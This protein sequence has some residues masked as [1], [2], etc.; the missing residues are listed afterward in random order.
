MPIY[1]FQFIEELQDFRDNFLGLRHIIFYVLNVTLTFFQVLWLLPL[2][3]QFPRRLSDQPDGIVRNLVLAD[4]AGDPVP[5]LERPERQ[6]EEEP[7]VNLDRRRPPVSQRVL[8]LHQ[9][10]P[11]AARHLRL[12]VAGR[13]RSLDDDVV[14]TGAFQRDVRRGEL[15]GRRCGILLAA[16][17]QGG[18]EVG[19]GGAL[20]LQKAGHRVLQ[21]CQESEDE[22][23]WSQNKRELIFS[24]TRD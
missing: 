21:K 17:V 9:R 8:D 18:H 19:V 11:A 3:S 12:R 24:N 15:L 20:P 1:V 5:D 22:A 14:I 13:G 23:A 7:R 16:E 10:E 4:V 6:R 2:C